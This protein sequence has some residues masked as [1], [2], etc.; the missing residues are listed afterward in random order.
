MTP[1]PNTAQPLHTPIP[2]SIGSSNEVMGDGEGGEFFAEWLNI[3]DANGKVVCEFPGHSQ[4]ARDTDITRNEGAIAAFMVSAVNRAAAT[5][6]KIAALESA[7]SALLAVTD[8]DF[9]GVGVFHRR[10]ASARNSAID[11]AKAALA[12]ART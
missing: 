8:E 10:A 9:L 1:N 3:I 5:E 2:W 11:N 12:L 7:C 4:H 6:A